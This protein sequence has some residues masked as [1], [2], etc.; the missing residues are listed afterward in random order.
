M[1]RLADDSAGE[2]IA[3]QGEEAPRDSRFERERRRQLH[4]Q[5]RQS[6]AQAGDFGQ[7][8]QSAA[9][10]HDADARRGLMARGSL[11]RKAKAGRRLRGP[12]LVDLD[13][14]A[15]VERGIDLGAGEHIRVALEV[16][17][18]AGKRRRGI[19]RD[20]PSGGADPHVVACPMSLDRPR[21]KTGA[22]R[23]RA[24]SPGVG[25]VRAEHDNAAVQTAGGSR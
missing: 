18:L 21:G 17:A 20:R 24:R 23:A 6:I 25:S 15:A 9:R 16:T 22:C 8:S 19:A 4:Q 1:A 7:E 13:T 10:V 11:T 3:E 5:E 14:V 12:A 2:Q